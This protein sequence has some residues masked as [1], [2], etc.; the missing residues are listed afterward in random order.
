MAPPAASV[1]VNRGKRSPDNEPRQRRY[2]E[3]GQ[4]QESAACGNGERRNEV[5]MT[6]ARV[7]ETVRASATMNARRADP[8]IATIRG[9]DRFADFRYVVTDPSR[10]AAGPLNRRLPASEIVDATAHGTALHLVMTSVHVTPGGA[11]S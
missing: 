9:I 3:L 8:T 1:S 4:A 2:S 10:V 6:I 11:T 7:R 5:H